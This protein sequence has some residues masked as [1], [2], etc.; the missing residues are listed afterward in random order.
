MFTFALVAC[1]TAP[2]SSGS[3]WPGQPGGGRDT[4]DTG[5]DTDD[6]H[7]G[8]PCRTTVVD[9]SPSQGAVDFYYRSAI[10]FT[11]SEPDDSALI[12]TKIAGTQSTSSDGLT[13]RWTPTAPLTP[14]T[15]YSAILHYCTG[16]VTIN[17]RT[18]DLGS[19]VADPAAL[20]GR[21][22]KLDLAGARWVEPAGLGS[23]MSSSFQEMPV[24]LSV[25]TVSGSTIDV[26]GEFGRTAGPRGTEPDY[27][28]PTL[29]FPGADFSASPHVEVVAP[30]ATFTLSGVA[31]TATN[32]TMSGDFSADGLSTGGGVIQAS[33]DTRPLDIGFFD[34]EIGAFCQTMGSLGVACEACTDGEPY[35]M[36]VQIEQIA[37]V[38]D[39]ST[40]TPIAGTDCAGCDAGI[41]ADVS[42]SCPQ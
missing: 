6:T 36:A 21:G 4:G 3:P 27:C 22:Y 26:F 7:T 25:A 15:A 35:C 31:T 41:P 17:F 19:P 5:G 12:E 30:T 14:N 20:A 1:F 16:D 8:G 2:E 32:V 28:A 23:V 37:G 9:V 33:V 38:A 13:V 42:A 11:L 34:G 29:D 18:S 40:M 39:T 24:Y 10:E